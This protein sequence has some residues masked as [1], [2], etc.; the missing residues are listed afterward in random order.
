MLKAIAINTTRHQNGNEKSQILLPITLARNFN[1][2]HTNAVQNALW[3]SRQFFF[4][5]ME[6]SRGH[7]IHRVSD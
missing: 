5:S 4:F 6:T 7:C 3:I 2:T 1:E